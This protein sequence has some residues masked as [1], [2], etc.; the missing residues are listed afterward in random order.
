MINSSEKEKIDCQQSGINEK[1]RHYVHRG[2]LGEM[3][4]LWAKEKKA[5]T[6]CTYTG[7]SYKDG[8]MFQMREEGIAAGCHDFPSNFAE[9]DV[10]P[11]CKKNGKYVESSE[12]KPKYRTKT[13]V[14][15]FYSL[16]YP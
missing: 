12:K 14:S 9:V 15:T 6:L 2:D 7:E 1:V 10:T 16:Q 5:L 3:S 8:K 13:L 11:L 4:P